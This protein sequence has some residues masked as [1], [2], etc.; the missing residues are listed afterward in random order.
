[1]ATKKQAPKKKAAKRVRKPKG[2]PDVDCGAGVATPE[3]TPSIAE[4]YPVQFSQDWL[5]EVEAAGRSFSRPIES[6]LKALCEDLQR[7]F[8]NRYAI[9]VRLAE[10]GHEF[11]LNHIEAQRVA[12][13]ESI[14]SD[15]HVEELHYEESIRTI[16]ARAQKRGLYL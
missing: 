10:I 5:E 8:P 9:E 15:N 16:R 11:R 6:I 2:A 13:M 14:R 12:Q 3:P 7:R 4:Q 1:M